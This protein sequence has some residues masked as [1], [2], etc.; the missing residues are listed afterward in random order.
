MLCPLLVALCAQIVDMVTKVPTRKM[1]FLHAQLD[2]VCK[3]EIGQNGKFTNRLADE[4]ANFQRA[5]KVVTRGGQDLIFFIAIVSGMRH[6]D[7]CGSTSAS[8]GRK[9]RCARASY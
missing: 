1:L 7:E 5:Q 8:L 6:H 9:M 2:R 3:T 4:K